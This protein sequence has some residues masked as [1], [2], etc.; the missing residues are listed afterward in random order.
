M[1]TN[2][3]SKTTSIK[4]ETATIR[5]INKALIDRDITKVFKSGYDNYTTNYRDEIRA[6]ID[7]NQR[8]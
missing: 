6:C 2:K 3:T 5:A 1:T 8:Y 4:K 7:I